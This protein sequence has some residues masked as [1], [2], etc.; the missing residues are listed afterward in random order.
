MKKVTMM[1]GL[2]AV[3]VCGAATAAQSDTS[4]NVKAACQSNPEQCAQ[5]KADAQAVK[6]QAQKT[7]KDA[8]EDCAAN[9]TQCDNAKA[10][11]KG[12]ATQTH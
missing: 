5:T 6:V 7:F 2:C 12:A 4:A 1:L 3:M 8:K 11:I 10:S 9:K